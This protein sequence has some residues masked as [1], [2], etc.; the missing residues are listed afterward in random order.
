MPL[1]LKKY[2]VTTF[3]WANDG[4]IVFALDKAGEEAHGLCGVGSERGRKPYEW[5]VKSQDGYGFNMEENRPEL[6]RKMDTF[7]RKH[8]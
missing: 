3:V 1:H 8:L 7:L 4:R 2:D 6:Y 5:L